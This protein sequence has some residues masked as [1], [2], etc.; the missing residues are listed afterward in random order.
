MPLIL[1][2]F[3]TI[4][5]TI[6]LYGVIIPLKLTVL[7]Q[8]FLNKFEEGGAAVIRLF[9]AIM[10]WFCAPVSHTPTAFRVLAVFMLVAALIVLIIGRERLQMIIGCVASWP[11]IV[12][13]SLCLAGVAFGAFLLWSVFPG[14]GA[15]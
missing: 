4:L 12:I 2:V 8:R 7:V 10:L 14:L 6:S 13:R 5:I 9:L 3:S 11:K 15:A 1:A